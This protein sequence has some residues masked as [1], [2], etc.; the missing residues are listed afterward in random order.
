VLAKEAEATRR[1]D[2]SP[3]FFIGTFCS[4]F[5]FVMRFSHACSDLIF[6]W[7][8][9]ANQENCSF[10]FLLSQATTGS[11]GGMNALALPKSLCPV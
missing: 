8:T 4:F 10:T 3:A 1:A 11:A 5:H 7:I 9:W 6:C 2:A